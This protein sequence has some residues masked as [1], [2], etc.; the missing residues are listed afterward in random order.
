MDLIN[1]F[2]SDTKG[3][4]GV[5]LARNADKTLREVGGNAPVVNRVGIRRGVVRYR[6]AKAHVVQLGCLNA[7][8]G[9][10]I[11]KAVS[12]GQRRIG[13]TPVLLGTGEVLDLML[14]TV[15][16]IRPERDNVG[17]LLIHNA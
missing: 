16:V 2:V 17:T 7:K 14:P 11:A 15:I 13:H 10:D 3:H 1:R 4:F 9:F 8:T 12:I 5:K 6:A